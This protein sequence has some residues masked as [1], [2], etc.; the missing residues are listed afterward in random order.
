M[1]RVT[2]E[3]LKFRVEDVNRLCKVWNIPKEFEIG[4]RN[5]Y[6]YLDLKSPNHVGCIIG[7]SQCGTKKEIYNNLMSMYRVLQ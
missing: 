6:T 7:T 2:K 4:Y 1:E 5:G 3:L